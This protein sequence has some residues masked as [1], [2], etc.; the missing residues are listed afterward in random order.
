MQRTPRPCDPEAHL[1]TIDELCRKE[2]LGDGSEDDLGLT[3]VDLPVTR[4]GCSELHDLVIEK[5]IFGRS[6]SF[7]GRRVLATARRT[8][9]VSPRWIFRSLGR[10]AANST[11]L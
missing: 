10:D 9:L 1:R 3:S 5:P 11:T 7:A 2:G 8:T 6:M 4:K